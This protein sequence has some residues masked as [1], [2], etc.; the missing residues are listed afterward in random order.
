M[1]KAPVGPDAQFLRK[2]RT[3][4]QS[5]CCYK[6]TYLSDSCKYFLNLLNYL[7]LLCQWRDREQDV[8]PFFAASGCAISGVRE[9]FKCGN[10]NNL[11][12]WINNWISS[13]YSRLKTFANGMSNDL[14]AIKNA[15]KFS[16]NNGLDEGTNNKLKAL[17]RSMYGR[18]GNHLL[19][20]KMVMSVTG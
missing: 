12:T 4:T 3:L 5:S 15:I 11:D 7:F 17:K 13:E 8:V 1:K 6:D 19:E 14:R 9:I 2:V 10:P 18:A 16:Y 20:I